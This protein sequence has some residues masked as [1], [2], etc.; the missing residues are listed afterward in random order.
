MR[1]RNRTT[2][3]DANPQGITRGLYQLRFAAGRLAS[4]LVSEQTTVPSD[5]DLLIGF[6]CP[7]LVTTASLF[8]LNKRINLKTIEN[9]SR[10]EQFATR[11]DALVV[12]KQPGPAMKSYNDDLITDLYTKLPEIKPRLEQLYTTYR[13]SPASRILGWTNAAEQFD[14]SIRSAT[15]NILVVTF[16]AFERTLGTIRKAAVTSG[17]SV[18]QFANLRKDQYGRGTW[19]EG[20]QRDQTKSKAGHQRKGN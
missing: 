7:V 13:F 17:S 9:S 15:N 6:V 8:V 10:L 2:S 19:V 1:K 16:E 4:D 18:V 11:V 20:F 12:A 3:A 14:R 5:D